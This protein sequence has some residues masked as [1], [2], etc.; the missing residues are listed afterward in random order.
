MTVPQGEFG[1]VQ[2]FGPTQDFGG[3]TPSEQSIAAKRTLSANVARVSPTLYAA[4]SRTSLTREEQNLIENWSDIKRTHESLMRM[5][6]KEADATFK[7]LD[8][9][10]QEVL[11]AYFNVDYKYKPSDPS[12]LKVDNPTLRNVFGLDNGFSFGD[13]VKS[14]FKAL[15]GLASQYGKFIN[16]PYNA[17]Q[18]TAFNNKEFFSNKNWSDSFEG[19]F[20]YDENS[21]NPLISKYGAATS[22]VAMHLL[23]GET[24]GEIIN[25]WG[26][27]DPEILTAMNSVFNEPDAME[28]MLDEFSNAQLSPGRDGTRWLFNTLNIDPNE[29]PGWFDKIS[30][31]ADLAWQIF[32]DPLTYVTG[33]IWGGVKAVAFLNKGDALATA[34]KNGTRTVGEHL[35]IPE[36]A[37]FWDGY[38][39]SVG[40]YREA[41]DADNLDEAAKIKNSIREN[42]PQHGADEEIEFWANIPLKD[43]RI[44]VRD[45]ESFKTAWIEPKGAANALDVSM[46]YRGKRPDVS[47]V[48]EGAAYARKSRDLVM[49]SKTKLRD[50]FTGK[51]NF[52]ELDKLSGADIVNSLVKLGEDVNKT[53]DFKEV[54]ETIFKGVENNL[55]KKIEKLA[56]RFPG[57]KV[58]Y[59]SDELVT[60][61]LD[62]F[63]EQ[64][65]FAIGDKVRAELLVAQ[66][67]N[68]P[69]AL[70]FD[71][72]K[73]VD[74]L[75][76]RRLGLTGTE[77]GVKYMEDVLAMSYGDPKLNTFGSAEEFD[78]PTQL[79]RPG[80]KIKISG[81][82]K[83][84]DFKEGIKALPWTNIIQKV[85][86]EKLSKIDANN[87]Q[88]NLPNLIGGAYKS[89]ALDMMMNTW[90][91]LTLLPQLGIRTAIDEG[92][93]FMM[94]ANSGQLKNYINAKRAGNV[95][96]AYTRDDA[97]T[98]F[99]KNFFQVQLGKA[100]G[101]EIGAV[102]A[103]KDFE[104]EHIEKFH[105]EKMLQG[106]YKNRYEME[107]AA[108]RE[109]F[110]LAIE[111][112]GK[113][114]PESHRK[115][116]E[117]A[118]ML[119]PT[120]LAQGS[121]RNIVEAALYREGVFKT[122]KSII[123]ESGLDKIY[124]ELNIA[125]T[126]RFEGWSPAKLGETN[127]MLAQ[128]KNLVTAFNSGPYKIGGK[129]NKAASPAYQFLKNNGLYEKQDWDK[130][131]SGL[132][133]SVGFSWNGKIWQISNERYG[134]VQRFLNSSTQFK[135]YKDLPDA[136]KAIKFFEVALADV[137]HRFHGSSNGFNSKLMNAFSPVLK[138]IGTD[139]EIPIGSF[140]NNIDFDDYK[141]LIKDNIVQDRIITDLDFFTPVNAEAWLAK[142]GL[143]G[144]M[145]AMSRQTDD[146]FRQ[147]AIHATYFALRQKDELI[148]KEFYTNQV[149]SLYKEAIENATN[150]MGRAPS[151]NMLP[152][153]RKAAEKRAQ[154]ITD[155]HFAE[156]RMADA[157]DLVLKYSDNPDIRS[158]LAFQ[159]KTAARFYRAVEDFHR[160]SFRLVSNHGLG[161]IY[162]LR[163]MQQGLGSSGFV[164]RDDNGEMYAILP[165]DDVIYSAVNNTLQTLSGKSVGINQP[166]FND[167]TF[168]LTG[169]NPSF[170]DDAGMPY[171]SGPV[172]AL[173]VLAVKS[174]LGNFDVTANFAEDVDNY[175]LGTLGDNPTIR[176][177]VTPKLVN[178]VWRM[179]K[180]DERSA[181]EVSAFTQ[182]ISYYQANGLGI[183][184]KDY[185]DRNTGELDQDAYDRAKRDYIASVRM[186]AHNIIVVRSLLGMLLPFA[187]QRKDTKDLPD[188]LKDTG[189][190]SLKSSFYDVLDSVRTMYPDAPDHYELALA[191][192]M[193]QNPNKIVYLVSANTKEIKPV[194]NYTNQMQDWAVKNRDAI[195]K[196]GLGTMIFAPN[197]GEFTPGVWRWAQG[198]GLTATVPDNQTVSEY[199]ANFY[200][201][202]LLKQSANAYYDLSDQEAE[203]LRNIPFT[204]MPLRRSATKFFEDR[205]KSLLL[206]VPGLD[207]YI[208]T[209]ADNSAAEDFV[210]SIHS[211][212]NS[213]ESDVAPEVT[214]S[215]NAAYEA[216][217]GFISYSNLVAGF[218]NASE[219]K[220]IEKK[221]TI[222]IIQRLIAS[223]STGAVKQ[224]FEYGLL[225]L[226]T[227]KSRDASAGLNRNV[228]ME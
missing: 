86:S 132:M 164:H 107:Q 111:R 186:S 112:Y 145:E 116:L 167:L 7:N 64:A 166:L 73:G 210:Q 168:K 1:P 59:T 224:Y 126:G 127:T 211:Y 204:D 35:A 146:I 11:K 222:D 24:P 226:M 144:F 103:I 142:F 50:L 30:G 25:A 81:P 99:V 165:M 136:E 85:A 216:Y 148:E 188:Y 39:T 58:V 98:G 69:E 47:Y 135:Q 9:Q 160:R 156:T 198:A 26:P 140:V 174:F 122:E 16:T 6:N 21:V 195:D 106:G 124:K 154:E 149:N 207:N 19:K 152:V 83:P 22:F 161:T 78:L 214:R 193:G 65:Y 91:V 108:R 209:G 66:F 130:A 115:W 18:N 123:S 220:R 102:R 150:K 12:L 95:L 191:T 3:M 219:L 205:R 173:S 14:P 38:T 84:E 163:L 15:L 218:D 172:G 141:E 41:L 29:Q 192:W 196:Y 206:S 60:K 178:N 90:T 131:I 8:P 129:T 10:K 34:L 175:A 101:K 202:I 23:A 89:K 37:K 40:K 179:L 61:S 4:A 199:F 93:M 45:L 56:A 157:A 70:R 17:M 128:Y 117:D 27:N 75:A 182:A 87:I 42:F 110:G 36:V 225:K 155:R 120:I 43:G 134:D 228:V 213:D 208:R 184:Y 187:S 203:Q 121:S 71:I 197:S 76:M 63:R 48:R 109:L 77:G 201:S 138:S 169:A 114:L 133:E 28:K 97:S 153:Y 79:G 125:P 200:D 44:G 177:A 189:I 33:G 183:D 80:E 170:Q 223:D 52:D 55:R 215:I 105:K 171:L 158:T 119:N 227:A 151:E 5:N 62:T 31:T 217:S 74:I 68:A 104:I 57:Q 139:R 67:R 13:I 185:I 92:F 32:A 72:K 147:P 194:V 2:S 118:A 181:E 100:L 88:Q 162:R 49:G 96:T 176:S 212:I 46:L 180:P 137:Y 82:I 143:N 94:Y 53:V 20:L 113:K 51:P 221:K 159:A 190:P 54:D